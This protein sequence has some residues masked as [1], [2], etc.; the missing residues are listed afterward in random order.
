MAG[1]ITTRS[2]TT[3]KPITSH[4]PVSASAA[5]P[6]L[7][8]RRLPVPNPKGAVLRRT[9]HYRGLP[10]FLQDDCDGHHNVLHPVLLVLRLFATAIAWAAAGQVL[11]GGFKEHHVASLGETPG[12]LVAHLV[13]GAAGVAEVA[14]I[15]HQEPDEETEIKIR[16]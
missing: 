1:K 11:G 15:P 12:P 16:N 7:F 14:L 8:L 5:G 10:L 6:H 13:V 4:H 2:T 3:K 9:V